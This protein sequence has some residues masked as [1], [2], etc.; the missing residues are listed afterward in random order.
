MNPPS[1]KK[2][3]EREDTSPQMTDLG[4]SG[5]VKKDIAATEVFIVTMSFTPGALEGVFQWYCG[6]KKDCV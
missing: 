3:L 2:T 4:C 1:E 5:V 6:S